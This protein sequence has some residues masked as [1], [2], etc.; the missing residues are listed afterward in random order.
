ML[1]WFHRKF[2]PFFFGGSNKIVLTNQHSPYGFRCDNRW[3]SE[4][5]ITQK[6]KH[7]IIHCKNHSKCGFTCFNFHPY[8]GEMMHFDLSDGVGTTNRV[9]IFMDKK[10]GFGFPHCQM[11]NLKKR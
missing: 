7:R 8:L 5:I 11:A 1:K 9:L 4:R 2:H 6:T 10:P 3:R